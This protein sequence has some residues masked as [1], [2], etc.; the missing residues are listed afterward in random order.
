MMTGQVAKELLLPYEISQLKLQGVVL[1]YNFESEDTLE[2]TIAHSYLSEVKEASRNQLT[3]ANIEIACPAEF[4]PYLY[5]D[6]R[7]D[8]LQKII[9]ASGYEKLETPIKINE[10]IVVPKHYFD[11][12]TGSVIEEQFYSYFIDRGYGPASGTDG[13]R[14]LLR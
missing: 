5:P 3:E 10:E 12:A 6:H 8:H 13:I 11:L 4:I 2:G 7:K 9:E 1:G 14:D